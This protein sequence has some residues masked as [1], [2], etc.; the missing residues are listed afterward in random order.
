MPERPEDQEFPHASE[1]PLPDPRPPADWDLPEPPPVDELEAQI[2][3]IEDRA[4]KA[5]AAKEA[6]D[7]KAEGT[8]AFTPET[9]R[10]LGAGMSV[11]YAIIILPLCGYGLGWLGDRAVGGGSLFQLLGVLTGCIIAIWYAVKLTN[12]S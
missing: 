12:R 4:A 6:H 7:S 9:G 8:A 3:D 11:A 5:R 2:R 1:G 10:D